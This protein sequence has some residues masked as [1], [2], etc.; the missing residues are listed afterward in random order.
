MART[1]RIHLQGDWHHV[2]NRGVDREDIFVSDADR[3]AFE[4]LIAESSDRCDVTVASYCLMTNH[5]HLLLGGCIDDVSRMMHQ[6]ASRYAAVFNHRSGRTGAL[7][8][9]RFGSLPI[10]RTEH[11]IAES[12]YIDRNPLALTS[13]GA[14]DRFRWS[15]LGC[16]TGVRPAPSWLDPSIV[17]D[18]FE[19]EGSR[20][21]EFV[22]RPNP[23]DAL[24]HPATPTAPPSCLDV[25]LAVAE[26]AKSPVDTLYRYRPRVPNEPREMAIALLTELRA[27]TTEELRIRYGF[28]TQS[29]VRNAARRAR[30]AFRRDERASRLRARTLD[31]LTPTE[32][33]GV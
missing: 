1:N 17:L 10:A 22:Q 14:I 23:S 11:L 26:A 25:E 4:D 12:R 6:T 29:G 27:A 8:G 19:G 30:A 33:V 2:W 24:P 16:V 18:Q 7:F 31:L 28:R 15:S 13:I 32:V 3:R 5:I 9:G 21:L 20:Y